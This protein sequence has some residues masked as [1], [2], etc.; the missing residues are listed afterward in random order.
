MSN[1]Y[2]KPWQTVVYKLAI[3]ISSLAY[4]VMGLVYIFGYD[5]LSKLVEDFDKDL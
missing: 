4:V 3:A 5:S 2:W 1:I